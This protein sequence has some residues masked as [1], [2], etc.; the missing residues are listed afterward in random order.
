MRNCLIIL[1]CLLGACLLAQDNI[2][3]ESDGCVPDAKSA[4]GVNIP[5]GQKI[6]EVDTKQLWLCT[7]AT[8]STNTLIS[9]SANFRD[10]GDYNS[11][12]NTPTPLG[13]TPENTANKVNYTSTSSITHFQPPLLLKPILIVLHQL[14]SIKL[15]LS[16]F[17]QE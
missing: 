15:I 2:T 16:Q 8:A 12:E 7:A 14:N 5:I 3:P 6:Y 10:L 17:L 4:F 9:A 1:F 11:L 13:Y